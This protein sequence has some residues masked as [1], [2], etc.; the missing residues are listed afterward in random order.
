M[1]S[2][3]IKTLIN[4]SQEAW[5]GSSAA[6]TLMMTELISVCANIQRRTSSPFHAEGVKSLLGDCALQLSTNM[7]DNGLHFLW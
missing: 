6:T 7:M 1:K 2:R 3:L 5:R 4:Q